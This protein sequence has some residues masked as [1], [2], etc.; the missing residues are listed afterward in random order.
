[1][2]AG[3]QLVVHPEHVDVGSGDIQVV[4]LVRDSRGSLA[5]PVVEAAAQ[6]L[7]GSLI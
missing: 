6:T 4:R 5:H 7:R 2:G 3:C 1:M